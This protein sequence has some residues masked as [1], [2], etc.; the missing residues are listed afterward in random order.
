MRPG[1]RIGE[2]PGERIVRLFN[3]AVMATATACAPSRSTLF[4]PVASA[5]H[6]RTGITPQWRSG[7]QRSTAVDKRVRELLAQPLTAENAALVAVLSSSEIQAV[8][9]QLG[10]AGASVTASRTVPNPQFAAELRFPLDGD[11]DP[12]IELSAVQSVTGLLAICSKSSVADAQLRATRRQAVALTVDLAARARAAF[13][14][15]AAAEQRLS[16]RRTI[17]Q[18]AAASA[19]LARDLRAAGNI[20]ELDLTRETVFEEEAGLEVRTA[21]AQS[22]TA[23]EHVNAVLGLQG[24]ETAWRI[25]HKIPDP[26]DRL[27]NVGDFERVAIGAS[28]DLEAPR[29]RIEAAGQQIGVARMQSFLPDIGIG[30]SAKREDGW[31]VGPMV[32]LSVPIFDWGQGSRAS[33]WAELRRLQHTYTAT[34][35]TVR[36]AARSALARLVA[37]HH[38]AVRLKNSVLPLRERL[39][40]EALRQY[41]AMNLDAFEL[42]IIRREHIQAEERYID[43]LRD[44]WIAQTEVD[45]LRAGSLP[46]DDSESISE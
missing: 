32:T 46:R 43:A 35:V 21:E 15:A 29:W 18:Q 41:N 8:Y 9:A 23:R 37:A 5:V 14:E 6:D 45:Q 33:A 26:P 7:W 42:L 16:L 11:A 44:Y 4:D 38:N 10:I 3:L 40:E 19:Q 31:G 13:F 25:T 20:T 2:P 27:P 39:V 28:L 34:A 24:N 30:V 17:A 12:Q 36:T 1:E 22:A